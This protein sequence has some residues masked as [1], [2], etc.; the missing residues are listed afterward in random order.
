SEDPT[1]LPRLAASGCVQVLVGI[2][3]LVFRHPGM[4]PKQAELSRITDALEAIQ[5]AGVAVIGCFIVGSDGET[6]ASLD[7]LA[8][9]I[10]S[11]A[12]ADVQLTLQT[13]FPGTQLR[14][15]LERDGRLLPERG[16]AHCTLFDLTYRPDALSVEELEAAFRELVCRVYCPAE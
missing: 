11:S 12:L 3:S 4:G 5:A 14:R 1:L 2:E 6:R 9:F 16:W 13:P 15:R 7:R 8:R 10:E